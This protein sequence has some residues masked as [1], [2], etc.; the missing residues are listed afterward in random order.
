MKRLF[1]GIIICLTL[2]GSAAAQTAQ[3]W[4]EQRVQLRPLWNALPFTATAAVLT[5]EPAGAYA[6]YRLRKHGRY[7]S[8]EPIYIYLEPIGYRFVNTPAGLI[9]GFDADVAFLTPE[10]ELLAEINDFA[11]FEF[12]AGREVY[13]VYVNITLDIGSVPPGHYQLRT[14]LRDQHADAR[15]YALFD[16]EVA[17]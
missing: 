11:R 2:A 15:V 10:G 13:E 8:T 12:A 1:I 5:A 17:P 14:T 3:D 16:I 6:Q 7:S 4:L 9:F